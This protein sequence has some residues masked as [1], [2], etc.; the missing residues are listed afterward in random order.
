VGYPSPPRRHDLASNAFQIYRKPTPLFPFSLGAA[1]GGGPGAGGR[2]SGVGGMYHMY[3]M[4]NIYYYIDPPL[5]T[6]LFMVRVYLWV[7]VF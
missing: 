1:G 5:Y 7:V 3:Y 6:V 4:Y 2:G